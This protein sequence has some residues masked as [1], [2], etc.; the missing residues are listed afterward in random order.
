MGD[1]I[2]FVR[3]RERHERRI[4]KP[5]AAVYA[6][7]RT[8]RR[9]RVLRMRIN[10]REE[11]VNFVFLGNG[12]YKPRGF[13]PSMRERMDDG[14]VDVRTL[15]LAGWVSKVRM[16]VFFLTGEF[17]RSKDYR[18]F[19]APELTIELLDGPSQVARDGEVGE[20]TDRLTV[21]IAWRALT[22]YRPAP[23]L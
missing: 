8:L 13:A 1:Y 21:R 12:Q 20:S 3:V 22:T 9:E 17:A 16:L 19:A 7:M 2:D 18:E 4:G 23:L 15:R 14:L 6:A 10:G 11:D 5:L